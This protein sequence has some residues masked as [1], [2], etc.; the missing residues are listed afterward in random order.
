MVQLLV[1]GYNV[2]RYPTV[3]RQY[4]D[5]WQATELTGW[6]KDVDVSHGT[7]LEILV[8]WGVGVYPVVREAWHLK[9]C[10]VGR[11]ALSRHPP[12]PAPV[13]RFHRLL[14]GHKAGARRTIAIVRNL[15]QRN[16]YVG[17]RNHHAMN[18]PAEKCKACE[19]L[20]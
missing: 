2:V 10:R 12:P 14:P 9:Y 8:R 19:L 15:L 6:L 4:S 13:P 5:S 18:L 3:A 7:E 1:F 17:T 16:K 11:W 20:T